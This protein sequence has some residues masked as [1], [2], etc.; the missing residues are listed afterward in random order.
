MVSPHVSG[1]IK[2]RVNL[3]ITDTAFI[4][5]LYVHRFDVNV[6]I[7]FLRGSVVTLKTGIFDTEVK[8]LDVPG[9]IS[10]LVENFV[11]IL[12]RID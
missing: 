5:L 1:Q 6:K 3:V 2:S 8:S 11:T 10:F 4:I 9:E 7:G 12:A